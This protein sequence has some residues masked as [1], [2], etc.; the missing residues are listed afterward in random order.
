M[1]NLANIPERATEIIRAAESRG[2]KPRR[3][4]RKENSYLTEKWLEYCIRTGLDRGV[5][6]STIVKEL[7]RKPLIG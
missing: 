2:Y 4:F 3:K 6:E 5:S 7:Y 1:V